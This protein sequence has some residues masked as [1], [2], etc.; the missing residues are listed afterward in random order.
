MPPRNSSQLFQMELYNS[1]FLMGMEDLYW[2]SCCL[3]RQVVRVLTE[4]CQTW[5]S[6]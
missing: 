4:D 2:L 6:R 5:L 1:D 3:L